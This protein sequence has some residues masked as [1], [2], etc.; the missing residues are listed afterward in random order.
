MRKAQAA[1][2]SGGTG[3][4]WRSFFGLDPMPADKVDRDEPALGE[5]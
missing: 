2:N 5:T 1:Q 3:N 4:F